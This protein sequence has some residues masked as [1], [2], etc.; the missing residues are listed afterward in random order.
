MTTTLTNNKKLEVTEAD[1][2]KIKTLLTLLESGLYSRGLLVVPGPEPR[3]LVFQT[4]QHILVHDPRFNGAWCGFQQTYKWMLKQPANQG[5]QPALH[6]SYPGPHL[7]GPNWDVVCIVIDPLILTH[8]KDP[9]FMLGLRLGP[10]PL[11][12]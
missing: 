3:Q 6:I 9:S 4:I 10:A 11:L 8:I 7:R 2:H 12:F 5:T 1:T